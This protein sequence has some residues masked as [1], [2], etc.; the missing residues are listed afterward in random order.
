MDP[1]GGANFSTFTSSAESF[2]SHKLMSS[3]RAVSHF[4]CVS[5]LVIH[6]HGEGVCM[7][8]RNDGKGNNYTYLQST[9]N[10]FST[11]SFFD[12]KVL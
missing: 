10:F 11:L 3:G 7:G 9:V 1:G 4:R 8:V 6:D 12:K 5:V 2:Q